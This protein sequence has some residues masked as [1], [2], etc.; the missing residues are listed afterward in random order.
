MTIKYSP[1]P[2][3][4]LKLLPTAKDYLQSHPSV[5]FAYLF[6]GL[7]GGKL[8][9]LSDVDIAVYLA[10][11]SNIPQRTL[12]ILGKLNELLKTDEID[13]VVLNTAPLPLKVRVIRHNEIL[14]DKVPALRHSFESLTLREYFDFSVKERE[15][16]FRR[17]GLGR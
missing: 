14:V 8:R 15:I 6:G 3:D 4:I 12:E 7:V 17:F 9:P 16:L 1:L 10:E 5:L 13:L 2:K 11:D